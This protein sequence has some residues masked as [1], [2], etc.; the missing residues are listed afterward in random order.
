MD[1]KDW[2]SSACA[3]CRSAFILENISGTGG[4]NST[5]RTNTQSERLDREAGRRGT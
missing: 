2:N 5:K 1:V 4:S 3:D